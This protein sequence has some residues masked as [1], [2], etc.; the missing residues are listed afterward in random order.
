MA[1]AYGRDFGDAS[2]VRGTFKGSGANNM[3]VK[4]FMKRVA[5]K[6]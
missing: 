4:V 1:V 3:S 2:P 6:S 5:G